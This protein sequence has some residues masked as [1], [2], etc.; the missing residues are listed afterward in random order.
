VSID[1]RHRPIVPARLAGCEQIQIFD[2]LLTEDARQPLLRFLKGP[3]WSYGAFSDPTPGAPRYWYKHFAGLVH[4][5]PEPKDPTIYEDELVSAAPI[6]AQ[7]WRRLKGDMLRGHAL[8]RCYAN[9]YTYGSDGGLHFDSNV[10]THFTCIY[11][12][13]MTWHPNWAGETVFF[14]G[15]GDEI[16]ASVYPRP[17]R[18]LVFPGNIPHVARGVARVCPEMRITL[19]F[20]TMTIRS[21]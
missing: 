2:D 12:P 3:G 21:A 1:Y 15:A 18:L 4:D 6:I 14:N 8:T 7:M 5:G 13:H 20:K 9:G 19:M 10:A 17:N 11:Y 16:L